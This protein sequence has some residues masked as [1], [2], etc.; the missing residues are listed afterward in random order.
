MLIHK[1]KSA[2]YVINLDKL[3]TWKEQRDGLPHKE[4][5]QTNKLGY[6]K[7]LES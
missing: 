2:K 4:T 7:E 3:A 5:R 1:S 6:Y